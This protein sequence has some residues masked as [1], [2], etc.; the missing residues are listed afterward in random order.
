M[1]PYYFITPVFLLH[2]S[3]WD[4]SELAELRFLPIFLHILTNLHN[5]ILQCCNISK[6]IKYKIYNIKYFYSK[7]LH[8]LWGILSCNMWQVDFVFNSQTQLNYFYN[9]LQLLVNFQYWLSPLF[10][11]E[12]ARPTVG[13]SLFCLQYIYSIMCPVSF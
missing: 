3:I 4:V 1:S 10:D 5:Q 7:S 12:K 8:L 13:D 9:Y 2:M 6:S 11:A